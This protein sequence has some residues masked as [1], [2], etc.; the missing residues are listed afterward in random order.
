MK[1]VQAKLNRS[2]RV[3]LKSFGQAGYREIWSGTSNKFAHNDHRVYQFKWVSYNEY[4]VIYPLRLITS[5]HGL[6]AL[7]LFD[8]KAL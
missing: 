6:I 3:A 7:R 1:G 4:A 2:A 5:L 8:S